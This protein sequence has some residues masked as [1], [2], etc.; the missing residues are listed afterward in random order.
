MAEVIIRAATADDMAALTSLRVVWADLPDEPSPAAQEDFRRRLTEWIDARPDTLV[1]RVAEVEQE[2]VGMAWLVLFERVPNIDERVRMTG[3]IQSVFVR[4][5]HRR[6]GIG[7]ALVAALL[8]AADG[9]GIPRVTVSAGEAALR[10]YTDVGF[11][12]REQLLERRR[13]PGDDGATVA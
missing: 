12:P 5:H 7:H 3:D 9:M 1:I 4:P 11:S 6:R 10:L 2:L 8:A 13:H